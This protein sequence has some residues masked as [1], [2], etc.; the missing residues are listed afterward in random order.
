MFDG[1]A[2]GQEI[3]AA[4]KLHIDKTVTPM[5]A[6]IEAIEK[7]FD[8]LPAPRDGKDADPEII[9]SIVDAA[10]AAYAADKAHQ[11]TEE[12][13]RAIA[14]E[15]ASAC[16]S[17]I[18]VP[19]DG[20]D[21]KDADPDAVWEMVSKAVAAL[22]PPKD[23]RDGIDGK[24]VDM[25]AV[26]SRL[27]HAAAKAIEK[28]DSAIASIPIPK[29]G[30]SITIEDVRPL[31]EEAAQKAVSSIPVPKDGRDG[32]DGKDG[33]QLVDCLI[34]KADHLIITLSDGRMKDVGRV[35]GHDGVDVD[36]ERVRREIASEIKSLWD[37]HPKPRD[38]TD[39]LGFEDMTEELEDDGRTIVRRY[40]RDGQVKEF[41][42]SIS[43]MIYRGVFKEGDQYH[44][45]DVVTWGGHAWHCDKS[46]TD[47]P[48]K[49]GDEKCWTMM[50]RRGRDGKDAETKPR[51]IRT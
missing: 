12:E 11:I 51:A 40:S 31:I 37:S 5:M 33:A 38:G 43:A 28:V 9:K 10:I 34:D 7:R 48:D 2:F 21:G 42:H 23:G 26:F 27:D 15:E 41:R 29:D 18:P 47:K 19:K 1:K 22:A 4:V 16:V 20:K 39:G 13:V 36:L 3:V 49:A 32:I 24:D 45:G 46:T 6:R 14:A 17:T 35:V 8:D 50:V 30:T 44:A 25:D